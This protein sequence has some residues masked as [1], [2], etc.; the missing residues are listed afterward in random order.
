MHRHAR[1]L[2]GASLPGEGNR[3]KTPVLQAD[4]TRRLPESIKID[5]H[6]ESVPS[7]SPSPAAEST[8]ITSGKCTSFKVWT[9]AGG[10]VEEVLSGSFPI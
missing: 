7:R 4:Q 10:M 3:S 6:N 9:V 1:G 2:A 5:N 8:S